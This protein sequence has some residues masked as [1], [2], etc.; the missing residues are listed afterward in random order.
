MA[1]VFRDIIQH[2]PPLTHLNLEMFSYHYDKS[3]SVAKIILEALL[4][5]SISTIKNLNLSKNSSWFRLGKEFREDVV[6]MLT[7][8]ISNQKGTL[9]VLELAENLFTGAGFEKLMRKI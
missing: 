9:R 6:E 1:G 3:D 7:E 2:R 8:V 5:S 4:N